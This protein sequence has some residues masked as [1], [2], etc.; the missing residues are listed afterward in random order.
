MAKWLDTGSAAG[1]ILKLLEIAGDY[2]SE[3]AYDFRSRFQL[4]YQEIGVSVSYEEACYLVAVLLRD[5]SSWLCAAKSSWTY[6]VS[7]DWIVTQDLYNL[8]LLINSNRKKKPQ[9]YPTP[10]EQNKGKKV[11]NTKGR[12]QAEIIKRLE[13]MNPKE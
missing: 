13:Q 12:S 11:G 3:I 4:S 5:T 1:G 6:P 8:T 10:W 9:M 7:R 2:P